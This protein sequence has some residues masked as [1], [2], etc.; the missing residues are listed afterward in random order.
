[1]KRYP[2]TTELVQSLQEHPYVEKATE[3]MVSFT[4]DF[5]KLA[6]DEYHRGKSM[7]EIFTDAGFDIEALGNK[8]IE[9][10]R[11]GLMEQSARES[12][13][14]DLRKNRDLRAAPSTEAQL[15]K[16]INELTHQVAYLQQENEFL[17]KIQNPG[18]VSVGKKVGLK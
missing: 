2:M 11:N 15:L 3:W 6:F 18:K 16:R 4:E 8:R 10:F 7:K 5:K 14:T 1:M 17:K 12:G 13:F 9:N